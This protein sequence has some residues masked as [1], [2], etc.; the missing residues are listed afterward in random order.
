MRVFDC[1]CVSVYVRESERER[2]RE[3][4]RESDVISSDAVPFSS[5]HLI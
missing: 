2:E 1:V 4:E 3:R 5:L